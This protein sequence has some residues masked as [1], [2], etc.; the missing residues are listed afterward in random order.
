MPLPEGV[1]TVADRLRAARLDPQ[2]ERVR[3]H[4]LQSLAAG[5][6]PRVTTLAKHC[7]LSPLHVR[8]ILRR[9]AALDLLLLD[10]TGETVLVAYPFSAT[11][12]PHRI[13]LTKR[14]VFALCAVDALGIPAMLHEEANISSSCA[15]CGSPVEVQ[16]RPERVMRY[17]PAETVVWFPTSADDGGP[18]A[19]SRCPS[20]NFFCTADHLEAWRQTKGQP[21]GVTLSLP[22]AFEAGREIFGSFLTEE[23]T[24]AKQV[25]VY[26]Q[27]G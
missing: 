11:P 8:E 17:L 1:K 27:P 22:E 15:H 4:L 12:T 25:I 19:E 9:L 2:E 6:T 13:L 18:V 7:G 3:R 16:A 23:E 24:M 26:T 20:T 5:V 21:P 10:S 14:E